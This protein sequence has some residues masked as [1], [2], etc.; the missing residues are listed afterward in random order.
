MKTRGLL[1]LAGM[2]FAVLVSAAAVSAKSDHV[3]SSITLSGRVVCA[4]HYIEGVWV[5]VGTGHSGFATMGNA[6]NTVTSTTWS[7]TFTPVSTPTNI[8]LHVGCGGST[9]AWWSDNWTP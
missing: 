8:R 9:S 4:V 3:A 2:L 1:M 6:G 5:E 7:Y